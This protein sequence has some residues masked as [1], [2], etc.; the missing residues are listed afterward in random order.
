[1]AKILITGAT[2]TIGL[3][4][5]K[6][7]VHQHELTVVG[8]DFSDFP[9][10]LK[11]QVNIEKKDL[12]DEKNWTGLLD[13]I[14]YVIQ[15]AGQ[16]DAE[17]E[18]YGDLLELNYKLPHNLYAEAK[19]SKKLK[20][21][22]FASSI[23]AVDAYPEYVQVKATDP[24]RPADLYGVSKVYL[25]GLASYYAY[26]HGMESIGIR[27]ADYKA[28]DEELAKDA[29]KNGMAM[30]L[31]KRDMNHL[32]NCCLE[33]EL[34]EPFLIINGISKNSFPRLS[35]EE[36][37]VQLGYEPQDD[38]FEMNEIFKSR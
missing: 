27:I 24:V 26:T 15:L 16:A 8:R 18:F 20:R 6:H 9:D 10:D 33:A 22:I 34:K 32:I 12:V 28:S 2:G 38:A 31:S 23:H 36:A 19:K 37:H 11:K 29:D 3:E 14:E 5:T 4:L 1:M 13:D 35:Y 17:A 21:I 25:E 7:L 30:F